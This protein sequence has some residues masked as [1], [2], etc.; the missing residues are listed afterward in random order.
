MIE[1]TQRKF[2]S[3]S[4]EQQHKKCAEFIRQLYE[5]AGTGADQDEWDAYN[6][7][8]TWMNIE[9]NPQ[10][11]MSPKEMADRYHWHLQQAKMSKREHHLLPQVRKGDRQEAAQPWEIGIYLDHIR[12]AHNVGSILRTVE[13]LRLGSIY[14]SE[15]TPFIDHKQ[16]QDTSMGAYAWVN[17]AQ[18]QDL[19]Q[20]KR[21]LIVLETS[22]DAIS[23]YD[24]IFPE[25]FTLAVG[26]EEYGCSDAILEAADYL[27]EI[28]IR[29]HKNS[30]NVANAFAIVAGEI[31]RQKRINFV[32]EID[33]KKDDT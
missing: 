17:C 20:L 7:L 19:A 16:V 31:S 12:S 27:V 26:N 28:P 8:L 25:T 22:P 15:Q 21:P 24:F 18:E 14:F 2:L 23:L 29:G 5:L 3:L 4:F 33:A 6:Q 9:T 13:A 30:L 11:E 10:E 32:E 1:F